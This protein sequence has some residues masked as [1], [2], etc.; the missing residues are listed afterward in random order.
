M[1]AGYLSAAL[2][3]A[4]AEPPPSRGPRVIDRSQSIDP[5]AL[6]LDSESDKL[7]PVTA[8]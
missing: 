3:C 8:A 1:F 2:G 6:G 7:Y 4:D 5:M